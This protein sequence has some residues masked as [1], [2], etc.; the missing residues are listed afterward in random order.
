MIK[1]NTVLKI[2]AIMMMLVLSL[3]VLAGCGKTGENTVEQQETKKELSRGKWEGDVYTSEFAEL[4]FTLPDG[5]TRSTDEEIAATMQ[6]GEEILAD[7]EKYNS[8]LEKLTTVYD[9]MVK[10]ADKTANMQVL[11]EKTTYDVDAYVTSL[12]EGLEEVQ[13]IPYEVGE[14]TETTISGNTYKAITA[15]VEMSGV[16]MEQSYYIRV[17][18]DYMVVIIV[19]TA[20]DI[21]V[22]EIISNFE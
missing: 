20:G 11:M 1:K 15:T 18:G 10:S 22:S 5:W 3:T 2:V 13:S 19:T 17:E 6:L 8:E 16:K 7:E 4:K 12:K 21:T 14:T 9:M